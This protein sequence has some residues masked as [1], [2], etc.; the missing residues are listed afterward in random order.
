M[1]LSYRPLHT[2]VRAL[3][4]DARVFEA[5]IKELETQALLDGIPITNP[6][7]QAVKDQILDWQG[8]HAHTFFG[9]LRYMEYVLKV[10]RILLLRKG[11]GQRE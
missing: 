9:S 5:Q 10:D 3:E 4:R 6:E 1:F 2:K 8:S 7:K 11:V